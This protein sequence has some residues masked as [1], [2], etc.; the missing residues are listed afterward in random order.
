MAN[1]LTTEDLPVSSRVGEPLHER[2]LTDAVVKTAGQLM[3]PGPGRS[4]YVLSEPELGNGRP[5]IIMLA[6]SSLAVKAFAQRG[7][8]L[9][10]ST[11]A[12]VLDPDADFERLGVGPSYGR[13]LRAQLLATGWSTS[14]AAQAGNIVHASLGIEAKMKDWRRAL[15]Q[16][17]RFRS[18][19][20]QSALLVPAAV[21]E[22]VNQTSLEFYRS[23]LLSMNDEGVAWSV[24]PIDQAIDGS[25]RLWLLELLLRGLEDGSAHKFS[26]VANSSRDS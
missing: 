2:V 9:P 19:V 21:A 1:G 11:A 24:P 5:D 18:S 8:R 6:A 25:R 4:V 17:S 14:L 10:H 3:P 13:R 15:R 20:G 7:L 12:R 26:A 23:G 16:V 22:K